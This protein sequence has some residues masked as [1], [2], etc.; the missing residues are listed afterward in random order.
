MRGFQNQQFT[1][2]QDVGNVIEGINVSG[3]EERAV[4]G[5]DPEGIRSC[6]DAGKIQFLPPRQV[7]RPESFECNIAV[8]AVAGFQRS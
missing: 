4:G 8:E 5:N 1:A 6:F 7:L 3:I 2:L